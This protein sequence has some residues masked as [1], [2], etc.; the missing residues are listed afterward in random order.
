[1]QQQICWHFGSVAV[2]ASL[3]VLLSPPAIGQQPADGTGVTRLVRFAHDAG[4]SY[5]ILE[6]DRIVAIEGDLFSVPRRKDRSY[7]RDSVKLLAPVE[8]TKILAAALNYKSHL[9]DRTPPEKPEFFFK[10]PSCVIADREAIVLPSG[11]SDVH[12]EAELVIVIGRRAKDVSPDQALKYVLG[13]TCGNDVSARD[14]QDGD[15][16]WW[17]AK[18]TDTFGPV[19]PV[20]ASGLDYDNVAIEGR[21]NGE[22]KQKANSN[23]LLFGIAEMVSFASRHVTLEPGDLIFT[24]APGT[25]T[26]LSAGDVFEVE[27]EGVGVLTNPVKKAAD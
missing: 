25:T 16:Q 22:V 26:P 5:G 18:G 8:P 4:V 2:A 1:M 11:S 9:A 15:I 19:G 17:R 23:D 10:P 7:P 6:G 24:G 12:Y 3:V 20:I 13:I 14:W 21:L 27:I